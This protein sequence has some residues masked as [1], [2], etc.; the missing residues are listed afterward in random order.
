MTFTRDRIMRKDLVR[1]ALVI[2]SGAALGVALGLAA[3]PARAQSADLTAWVSAGDVVVDSSRSARLT[4]AA[5]ESG[6]TPIGASSALLY[7]DLEPALR[8]AAG[9]FPGDT[10]EGSGLQLSFDTLTDTTINFRWTLSTDGYNAAYADR[11]F[12]VIDGTVIT[13]LGPVGAAPVSGLFSHTFGAGSHALAFGV[14]DVN[15]TDLVSTLAVTNF[16]VSAVP[17]PASGGLALLGLG[18]VAALARRRRS[19]WI[20]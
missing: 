17:E 4:T 12:V 3:A 2:A 8:V 14:L 19:A 10:F 1:G 9:T 6:E 16:N 11:G 18:G 15:S 5:V 7:F 13:A 20:E